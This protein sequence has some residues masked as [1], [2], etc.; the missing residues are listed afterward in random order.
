MKRSHI[1]ALVLTTLTLMGCQIEV[2]P[3]AGT[4]ANEQTIE[5][6]SQ[7]GS[8]GNDQS[9]S[10]GAPVDPVEPTDPEDPTEPEDP[11]DPVDP[12]EPTLS[13]VTLYWSAPV[14]RVNGD[15]MT[16]NDIGGYEIRYKKASDSSYTNV[17]I[18]DSAVDQHS[19]DDLE[20]ADD[21]TFEVAVFDTDG[22]Y[23]DFV[24]AMAN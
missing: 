18:N 2:T 12:G 22:I 13:S 20:N 1:I 16:I 19:I 21:Y 6:S 14:E 17:V 5:S 7:D 11:T 15:A 9:G 4:E 24:V 10:G 23:S 8:V 3:L